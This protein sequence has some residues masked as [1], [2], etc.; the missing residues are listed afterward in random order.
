MTEY[1]GLGF[2]PGSINDKLKVVQMT[3]VPTRIEAA[4]RIAE[5]DQLNPLYESVLKEYQEAKLW[6]RRC[7]NKLVQAVKLT[8]NDE[9][10]KRTTPNAS[11][12]PNAAAMLMKLKARAQEWR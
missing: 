3:E 7:E 10:V 2:L 9:L 5:E 8:D 1:D 12:S 6:M 11:D 4:A